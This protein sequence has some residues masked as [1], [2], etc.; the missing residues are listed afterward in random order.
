MT[1]TTENLNLDAPPSCDKH[2]KHF[3]FVSGYQ[4][5]L[6]EENNSLNITQYE[7]SQKATISVQTATDNSRISDGSVPEG[8]LRLEQAVRRVMGLPEYSVIWNNHPGWLLLE[9]AIKARN[10]WQVKTLEFPDHHEETGNTLYVS[11]LEFEEWAKNQ[12]REAS[13]QNKQVQAGPE[14]QLKPVDCIPGF[15]KQRQDDWAKA[16]RETVNEFVEANKKCPDGTELWL[17]LYNNPP[18]KFSIKQGKDKG[19][20]ALK[21]GDNK[22]LDR[23][24]FRKRWRRYSGK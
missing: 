5:V 8:H 10:E 2:W 4:E 23:E 1:N 9:K 20:D 17:Q 22:P 7:E 19:Q 21:L 15:P 14:S 13:A 6:I 16:I 12:D 3:M 11:W 24:A 18:A